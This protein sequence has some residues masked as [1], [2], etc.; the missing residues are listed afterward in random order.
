MVSKIVAF[1][2]N[3]VFSRK[4]YLLI[5]I[6]VILLFIINYKFYQYF[7]FGIVGSIFVSFLDYSRFKIKAMKF[8]KD[9]SFKNPLWLNYIPIFIIDI[10]IWPYAVVGI[11]GD[12]ITGA[13]Q[14]DIDKAFGEN[15]EC[16]RIIK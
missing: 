13:W 5:N 8:I 9:G 14:K 10:F 11:T 4:F 2:Y 7:I 12:I 6:L 3:N 16:V 1:I 15:N